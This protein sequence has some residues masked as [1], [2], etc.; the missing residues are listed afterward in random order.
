MKEQ[1]FSLLK[2]GL[3]WGENYKDIFPISAAEWRN[4]WQQA[5]KQT[6]CG[7]VFA[8]IEKLPAE[9][10]P[11]KE[12]MMQ[13]WA[14]TER[15]RKANLK[16]AVVAEEII[17]WYEEKGLKPTIIK[18]LTAG[19]LYEHPELRMP[20]DI[21]LF[22]PENYNMAVPI[23]RSK[24]IE[25]TLDDNHDVFDYKGVHVELHHTAFRPL[26]PVKNIDFSP[27]PSDSVNYKGKMLNVKANAMLLLIHPAKHFMKE[28]IGLRHLCDWAVFLKRYEESP[29]LS[30]AWDEVKRQGAERFAVE[31]TAIAV[32]YLGLQLKDPE[33]WIGKSKDRLREKMLGII[34][35]RGNFAHSVRA[36][37]SLY[38]YYMKL[39]PYFVQVY[40]FWKKF[41]RYSI[42]KRIGRR[43]LLILKGKPMATR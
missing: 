6:V 42:P 36:K 28:G 18:G 25:V 33:K 35:E 23:A 20:G 4:I 22:F 19:A 10:Q 11:P 21:D 40:Q 17:G 29:E 12:M 9:M 7:F 38:V 31:F 2:A 32:H 41:I 27:I 43:L 13:M 8:G 5:Q 37:N 34:M 26:F 15:I 39:F 14:F 3:G 16:M 30:E 1:F 24:G